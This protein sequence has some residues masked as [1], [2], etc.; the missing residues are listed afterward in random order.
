MLA[1][2]W[3]TGLLHRLSKK[4]GLL[5]A[6]PIYEPVVVADHCRTEVGYEVFHTQTGCWQSGAN[7]AAATS[8]KDFMKNM[9]VTRPCRQ[10]LQA[11]IRTVSLTTLALGCFFPWC[12]MGE[13][14]YS[15]LRKWTA[16]Y[17]VNGFVD[18]SSHFPDKDGLQ[19]VMWGATLPFTA[20]W[21]CF[22]VL[23]GKGEQTS[24]SGLRQYRQIT[25]CERLLHSSG[26]TPSIRKEKNRNLCPCFTPSSSVISTKGD[27]DTCGLR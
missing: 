21:Y 22:C 8:Q 1:Y 15:A 14:E 16:S 10:M 25:C 27:W 13:P 11:E 17:L 7:S 4:G 6:S 3:W 18:K 9:P 2:L 23:T 24:D 12:K 26:S 5:P 20:V 19:K